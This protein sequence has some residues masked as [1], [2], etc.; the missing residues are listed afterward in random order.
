M[1]LFSG[2]FDQDSHICTKDVSFAPIFV[3]IVEKCEESHL[4]EN[5]IFHKTDINLKL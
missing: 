4:V 3:G 5:L 1:R 2:V